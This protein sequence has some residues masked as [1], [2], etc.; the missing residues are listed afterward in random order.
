MT[1]QHVDTL[2]VQ[3]S[4]TCLWLEIMMMNVTPSCAP[5][6]DIIIGRLAIVTFG[7]CLQRLNVQ[8]C[9]VYPSRVHRDMFFVVRPLKCNE[10]H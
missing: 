7:I 5:V 8:Y 6:S 4:I 3:G 2:C 10:V 9:H 1:L